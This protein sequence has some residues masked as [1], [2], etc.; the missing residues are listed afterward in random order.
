MTDPATLAQWLALA[1][2]AL[3]HVVR[4]LRRLKRRRAQL[5]GRLSRSAQAEAQRLR[6]LYERDKRAYY[7]SPHWQNLRAMVRAR[8]RN[9]CRTCWLKG[10]EAVLDVHHRTYE[11]VGCEWLDDLVLL[12]QDCHKAVHDYVWKPRKRER[13]RQQVGYDS[14]AG[15]S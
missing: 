6:E 14:C 9:A 11:R 13:Y 2:L 10:T 12:C 4:R 7:A 1:G 8:D 5:A 15:S 3:G